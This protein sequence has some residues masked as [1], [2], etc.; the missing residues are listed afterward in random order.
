MSPASTAVPSEIVRKVLAGAGELPVLP[1]VA[2]RILEEVRSPNVNTRKMAEFVSKD[3]V[4]ASTVLRVANSVLYGGRTEIT[5]LPFAM[6]R[7][8][9]QQV[10]NLVLAL[11][12]RSRMADPNV[13][14]P[15]GNELMDHA[16]AVAFGSRLVADA[17]GVESDQSFI[18]GLL[19]DFGRLVLVKALREAGGIKKGDLPI[20]LMAVVDAHHQ[21][22]GALIATEWRFPELVALSAR[23]HH[24]PETVAAQHPMVAVVSF[25]DVLCHRLGLGGKEDPSLNL[26]EHPA[27]AFLKLTQSTIDDL[28]GHLPGLFSTARAA[29]VG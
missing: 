8:G 25:A 29:M 11:V 1:N 27:T 19:H 13:Y 18:C 24:Q 6:V 4:L 9:L 2:L 28:S 26:L 15:M 12:L 20:E 3:P 21:E 14:G 23:H 5:D 7:I 17:T 22:A 10:R 16:L